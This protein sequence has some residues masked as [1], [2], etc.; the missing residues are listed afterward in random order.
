MVINVRQT[1]GNFTQQFEIYYNKD[2]KFSAKL[3]TFSK[4]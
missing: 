2:Y 4:Y 1:H 3:G